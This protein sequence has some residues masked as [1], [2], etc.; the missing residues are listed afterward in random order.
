MPAELCEK[1][2]LSSETQ[3][4]KFRLWDQFIQF[5]DGGK[6]LVGWYTT[7]ATQFWTWNKKCNMQQ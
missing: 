4:F 1:K 2:L 7:I 3:R 6:C 5:K